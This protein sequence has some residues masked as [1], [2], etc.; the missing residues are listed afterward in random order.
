MPGPFLTNQKKVV[1]PINFPYWEQFPVL[2][3]L[4]ELIKFPVLMENDAM[5]AAM[6]EYYHGTGRISKNFYYLHLG[7][8]IGGAM[9]LNGAPYQ[10]FSPNTGELGRIRYGMKG[11]RAQ[12]GHVLGLRYLYNFLQSYG[13]QVSHP[14][15]LE[16]LLEQQNSYLWQWFNE[17][18][19][20]LDTIISAINAI[21]G[22][23]IIFLGGHF[24]NAIIDY[25]IERLQLEARASRASIPDKHT[26]FQPQIRRAT[27]GDLSSALGAATL[28]LYE[29]FSI[30]PALLQ[31]PEQE[32]LD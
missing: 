27:S 28:P 32:S 10:G 14:H 22:P 7:A 20:C 25:L 5:A 21:L 1:L 8:G 4:S 9:I 24:P 23:E 3:R 29:S 31:Q 15:E 2:E 13:L 12:I 11:P 19:D 6:A 26:L 16:T 17:A 30:Q 18:V